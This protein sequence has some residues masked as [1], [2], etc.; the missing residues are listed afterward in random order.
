[1]A[2]KLDEM[3]A[4]M[5]DKVAEKVVDIFLRESEILQM[6]Q[7]DDTVS[8]Q[9]G[10]TMT[11]SYMQKVLPSTANFRALNEEY[12]HSAATMVKKSADLKIFGGEFDIDR[13]LKKAEGKFNNMAWQMEEKI[14]AAVSLFHYTLINGNS[15]SNAK[16]F[17]GL[18]KML[19]GTTSELGTAAK[20]DLSTMT[21]LKANADEF[22]ELLTKLIR[23]TEADALLM[24]SD[25]ITKIQTVARVLG[26]KTESEEAFGKKVT[27]MDGVRLMDMKNHYTVEGSAPTANSVVKQGISRTIGSDSSATTGLTDI[28]AVK[29]DLNDGFHAAT[30]SGSKAIDQYLPDF[31]QPGVIKKG[32]V[33]MV[34]ATVLKNTAHAGVLRNIKIA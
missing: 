21:A 2:F 31:S 9:G 32:E 6:L 27:V 22:Y 28:Y 30:L 12:E 23:N 18:D 4:G 25:M 17:D 14:R 29:F 20:V 13:V 34:A 11:Y 16:E 26:Y 10:S 8:P 7:F 19:A 3:K 33:E 24:N 15:T 5:S 1:M